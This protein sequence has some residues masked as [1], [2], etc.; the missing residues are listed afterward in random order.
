MSLLDPPLIRGHRRGDKRGIGEYDPAAMK[1][2]TLALISALVLVLAAGL[3]S[4]YWV[5]SAGQLAERIAA[6]TEEQRARGYEITYQGPEVGGFPFRL[7]TRFEQP[8]VASPRGWR[9]AGPVVRGHADLWAPFTIHIDFS[10]LHRVERLRKGKTGKTE[11]EA[12]RAGAVVHLQTSGR[13]DRG[14]AEA[15]GVALRRPDGTLSAE[16]LTASLG[17]LLPAEGERL[18]ELAFAG[19]A[20][21]VLLPEAQAGPLGPWL[22][23]IAFEATLVGDIPPGDEREMLERWRDSGGVLRLGRLELIWDTLD[24]EGDGSVGLDAKLRP[25]GAFATRTRG[26]VE[27]IDKLIAA[28]LLDVGMAVPAK[29]GMVA[30]GGRRDENGNTV[31]VLPVTLREGQLF[32]GPAPLIRISPVL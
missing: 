7:T 8:R 9:W 5:W 4:A 13:I 27:T 12:A 18:Q 25:E 1:R 31:V 15:E 30:L 23:H 6:W 20:R 16:R 26:A 24:L 14:T 29:I 32:L 17:P 21:G 11:V 22:E 10:G 2:R 3:L 19:Q 28:G